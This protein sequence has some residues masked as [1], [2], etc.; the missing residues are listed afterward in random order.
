MKEILVYYLLV[1]YIG[2]EYIALNEATEVIINEIQTHSGGYFVELFKEDDTPLILENY[3]LVV[4][5]KLI[6]N[7]KR[8]LQVRTIISLSE[9]IMKGKFGLIHNGKLPL[10]SIVPKFPDLKYWRGYGKNAGF[11]WLK[12]LKYK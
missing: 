12:V 9:S 5:E 6:K 2:F 1:V 11:E 8:P 4:V 7:Q 10:E 3:G